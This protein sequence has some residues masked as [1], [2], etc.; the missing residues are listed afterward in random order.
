MTRHVVNLCLLF[1]FITLAISGV[2][3]FTQPFSIATTRV[4]VVFALSTVILVGLHLAVR[5]KYFKG[6]LLGAGKARLPR[7][8]LVAVVAGWSLLLGLSIKDV[9]PTGW[10]LGQSYEAR[11]SRDIVRS[12]PMAGAMEHYERL[13]KAI[14]YRTGR[15][16]D[17]PVSLYVG[18][19]EKASRHA[20]V[21]VWAESRVGAM[22]ET[23]YVSPDVAYSDQPVW[24]GK[25]TPRQ[26]VLPIWRHRHTLVSGIDPEGRVDGV[27]GATKSHQFNLA[28]Y[29]DLNDAKSF[30]LCVEVNKPADPDKTH[31]DPHIGQPSVLYTAYVDMETPQPYVLLELTGHGGGAERDGEIRYDLESLSTAKDIVE[32]LIARVQKPKAAAASP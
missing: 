2:L 5:V 22:I 6:L 8:V 24:N 21:A 23:L 19:R 15:E 11:R 18:L 3:A 1:A 30:V 17:T 26:H 4:H 28:A 12:S 16:G 13:P 25:K 29:L 27:S 20:S 32:L 7:T 14:A 10:L 31:A 9:G